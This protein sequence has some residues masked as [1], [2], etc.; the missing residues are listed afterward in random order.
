MWYW[1]IAR[2]NELFL[3]IDQPDR[4]INH[5]RRRLQGAI[6]SGKLDVRCVYRQRSQSGNR[7]HIIVTLN[8]E[9]SDIERYVWEI[10]LRSDLYR[11]CNNIMRALHRVGAPD[12]FISRQ[13][14]YFF[15]PPDATCNCR[16]K[17]KSNVMEHCPV[18][19]KYRGKWRVYGFFG[20]PSSA[21]CKFI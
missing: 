6:E 16:G 19:I 7:E 21:P 4:V 18:A 8:R 12:V 13:D 11:G 5:L 20:R 17:H 3:D 10:V 1:Y 2:R 15:R 14:S 9:L